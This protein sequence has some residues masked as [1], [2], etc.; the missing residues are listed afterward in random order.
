MLLGA[1]PGV[2]LLFA[3]LSLQVPAKESF[4]CAAAETAKASTV[5][6]RMVV[7]R[8]SFGIICP[9]LPR[10]DDWTRLDAENVSHRGRCCAAPCTPSFVRSAAII[11][12][13]TSLTLP[14]TAHE[15][16]PANR[17]GRRQ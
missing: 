12:E 11:F 3:T 6:A 17:S 7:T 13:S 16:N 9:P 14:A 4:G 1:G 8:A 2:Y 5:A 15:C 10:V